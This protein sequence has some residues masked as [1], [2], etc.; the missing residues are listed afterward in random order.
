MSATQRMRS[1]VREMLCIDFNGQDKKIKH[2]NRWFYVPLH[3]TFLFIK[4]KLKH[5]EALSLEPGRGV[6]GAMLKNSHCV[7]WNMVTSIQLSIEHDVKL[8]FHI[9]QCHSANLDRLF[10]IKSRSS[11]VE[12][13]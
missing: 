3:V 8:H 6:H 7:T 4:S 11:G 1:F 12:R 5:V 2:K 10:L 9:S 13:H